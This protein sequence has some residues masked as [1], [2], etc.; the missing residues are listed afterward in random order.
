[1]R[2]ILSSVASAKLPASANKKLTRTFSRPIHRS[3]NTSSTNTDT[4]ITNGTGPKPTIVVATINPSKPSLL[5]K[6]YFAVISGTTVGGVVAGAVLFTKDTTDCILGKND[7]TCSYWSVSKNDTV[8][9]IANC[10]AGAV[11]GATFGMAIGVG[12]PIILL[13]TPYAL[14]QSYKVKSEKSGSPPE[15]KISTKLLGT[16][17]M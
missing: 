17:I 14:Y 15:S 3:L 11:V 10:S 7:G 12:S 16:N 4:I 1:M 9:I 2:R 13:S 6:L 5:E 8:N